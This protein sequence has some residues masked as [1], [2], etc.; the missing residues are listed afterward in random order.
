MQESFSLSDIV[1]LS[2]SLSR[3]NYYESEHTPKR[4]RDVTE[5]GDLE[6]SVTICP[7]KQNQST[8]D[9]SHP[10]HCNRSFHAAE[11]K[12]CADGP[13]CLFKIR[14]QAQ[15]QATQE[16]EQ[17]RN[18]GEQKLLLGQRPRTANQ[19]GGWR[20][21]A[22]MA[23]GG[24]NI[25]WDSRSSATA[26]SWQSQQQGGVEQRSVLREE[27]SEVPAQG[28]NWVLHPLVQHLCI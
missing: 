2:W 25:S 28:A 12:K 26:S 1:Q 6:Y 9:Y 23:R 24:G 11:G 22:E 20:L 16:K 14:L 8:K 27:E 13:E 10:V 18:R 17:K 3:Q 19:N 7:A 21:E 4:K 15:R 5:E